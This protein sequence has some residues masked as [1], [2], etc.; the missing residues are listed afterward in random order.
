[1]ELACRWYKDVAIKGIFAEGNP[2]YAVFNIT[3]FINYVLFPIP[4][5]VFMLKNDVYAMPDQV[6]PQPHRAAVCRNK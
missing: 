5:I 3:R 1:M 2:I 4:T 6:L